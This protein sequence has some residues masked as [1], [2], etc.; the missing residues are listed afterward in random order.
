MKKPKILRVEELEHRDV[1]SC[2]GLHNALA[3]PGADH[4]S[5]TATVQLQANMAAQCSDSGEGQNPGS[6]NRGGTS[7][8]TTPPLAFMK[9]RF[10]TE[11]VIT[12]ASV[13]PSESIS[14]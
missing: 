13:M 8:V 5:D 2:S 12:K 6:K 10:P 1:P 3:S 14:F 9:I 11:I 4:R 7:A